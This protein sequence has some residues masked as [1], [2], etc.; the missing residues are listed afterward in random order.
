MASGAK[1][2]HMT[3]RFDQYRIAVSGFTGEPIAIPKTS[4]L[5][6]RLSPVS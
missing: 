6:T 4:A 3:A 1:I 2:A 5:R